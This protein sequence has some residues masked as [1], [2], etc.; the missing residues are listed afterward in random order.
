MVEPSRLAARKSKLEEVRALERKIELKTG[1]P[2]KYG[3]KW[4]AWARRFYESR[5]K[6]N[7]LC[8][9]NQISK[10]STQIRKCIEWA[11]N[12]S[13]WPSLW[14]MTPNQF[15]YLYPNTDTAEQEYETK[16]KLFLPSGKFKDDP[17]FGWTPVRERQKI[18]AIR[19]NS[20]V[21]VYFKSYSQDTEDLQAGT[22]FS[23]FCD[24]ELPIEHLAELQNR[25]NAT[26]GFF[27][28]VFTATLGQDFWRRAMEPTP[29]EKE[30]FPDA[31]KQTISMYDCLY[32][33]DNTPSH[34]TPE[35]IE[36][37]KRRCG[38]QAEIQ[39]RVYG[40]FVVSGGLK[41]ESFD[42]E[43]N[44]CEPF[45]IPASWHVYSGVDPG[46]GGESGH[47]AALCFVA[48]NPAYTEGFVFRGWRGDG[49]L[50]TAGDVL[51]E[52]VRVRGGYKCVLQQYDWESKDF[53][54]IASRMG[55]SF[56]PAEKGRANGEQLLNALFRNKMLKVFRGDPELE[57]LITELTSLLQNTPKTRAR[58]DFVDALR[59]ATV[60]IPWDWSIVDLKADESARPMDDSLP[61]PTGPIPRTDW[62]KVP[63][64]EVF[65]SE[66]EFWNDLL[67]N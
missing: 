49:I 53:F 5:E 20:G 32:Y 21:V 42:R 33:D 35:K 57:K 25:L 26:D 31:L 23:I 24:E 44:S 65:D 52:Y 16:W 41:Y 3:W 34:W 50:T 45:P 62:T 2:H 18:K 8:A 10:S 43:E 58:D 54:T 56:T 66:L 38:T 55:E 47:P 48:V 61:S 12:K 9:A 22:V 59:Y 14:K 37:V 36:R 17:E 27:H 51:S 40:R 67:E 46:S 28:M 60:R 29:S 15:W 1:L 4:Y 64:D 11:T 63:R 6:E 39:R 30:E 7:L 13:L 19:F